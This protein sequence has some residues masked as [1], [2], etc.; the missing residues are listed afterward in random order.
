M[1]PSHASAS[2]SAAPASSPWH[3]NGSAFPDKFIWGGASSAYQIEGAF[4]ADG[5]GLSVW[6]VLC[7]RQGAIFE[8][9]RGD[10]A[11]DHYRLYKDDVALFDRIGLQAYRF[12]VSWP[13][14]MPE[15]RGQVNAAGLA[16]YDRLVDELLARKITPWVTLFHW[17]Y[18]Y[19]LFVRGGWLNRDTV[20]W[21]GEYA[22]V[23]VDK[24]SDR[25]SHWMPINEP[26]V[27]LQLGHGDG[28]HAPG[29][30]LTMRE[31]LLGGHHVLMSHGRAVQVIRARAKT[32][33]TIGVANVCHV[34]SPEQDNANDITVAASQMFSIGNNNCWNNTWWG[35]PVVFGRYP[36]DG[37]KLFGENV[38]AVRS[39]DMDLIKQPIDFFGLNIYSGGIVRM[40]SDGRHEWVTR[41]PGYPMTTFRWAVA[42]ES[43]RWGPRFIYER[44]KLPV[45]IT[46]NGMANTDWI[47]AD[48]RVHDPQR[49]DFLRSYLL[50]LHN[51][52]AD[53]AKIDAYFLWSVLDNFEWAEGYRE[54]FGITYVDF[55]TK[56][57]TLK[58]SALWYRDVIAT[59]GDH[60]ASTDHKP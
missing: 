60:L 46:E 5:K 17:D 15:G 31:V 9:H 32:K 3:L 37:I 54:R 30:K 55:E 56:K 42:P 40:T 4:D 50:N 48:G 24:L 23:I 59:N 52:I 58:D 44:Y 57:R 7:R 41:K 49:I 14:V 26:Q 45:I 33:P 38:P 39:G 34:A 21:F 10:S 43:L 11:C 36:E 2:P 1:P 27:F 13:R 29:V 51:A 18:P 8:G 53:G 12:S 35:D 19:E 47:H 20:D 28:T 16:F 6:D 25:V 22:Q